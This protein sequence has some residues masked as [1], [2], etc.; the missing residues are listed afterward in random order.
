M[1][2][3][4]LLSNEASELGVGLE[5]EL[6]SDGVADHGEG[7]PGA[8]QKAVTCHEATAVADVEEGSP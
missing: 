8:G 5:A 2:I 4:W 3:A 7:Y 1:Q 6:G